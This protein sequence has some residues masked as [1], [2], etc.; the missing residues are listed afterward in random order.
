MLHITI[1]LL[2]SFTKMKLS[3][4]RHNPGKLAKTRS[5]RNHGENLPAFVI[6]KENSSNAIFDGVELLFLF[7][8]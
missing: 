5:I 1:K 3:K 2:S 7:F 8:V 4:P 6:S